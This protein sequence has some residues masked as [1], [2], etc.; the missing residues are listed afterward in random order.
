MKKYFSVYVI[1][2]L[3]VLLVVL[4]MLYAYPKTELH[5][6]LNARHT[7]LQDVFFKYY[8]TL[9]E[10]PLYVIALIPLLWKKRELTVFYALCEA[11]GGVVVQILKRLFAA[12]RP[13]TVFEDYPDLVLPVVDGVRLHHS[14]SFPS[15][16]SSTFFIFFT[17]CALLLAYRY[18]RRADRDM[19]RTWVL[20]G[21]TMLILLMLAVL[22]GY[23][24]IYLSQHFL[25]DVCMGS[26]I[27]V[28][29]PCV[30]FYFCRNKILKF[31]KKR[32]ERE[33][34]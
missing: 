25:S 3:L 22:G 30:M 18:S 16:H 12:P 34:D 11:S 15:G 33:Q 27:G 17:C 6:L 1:A 7:A 28:V 9:A 29:V 21:V 8:S 14:S 32:N 31:N 2:Y 5:L 20:A 19:L 10:W 23:S 24:R 13:A 26:I 4:G